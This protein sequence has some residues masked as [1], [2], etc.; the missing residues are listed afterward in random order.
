VRRWISWVLKLA[1]ALVLSLYAFWTLSLVALRYVDPPTTGVQIQRRVEAMLSGHKYRKRYTFVP[2]DRI[3]PN[4]QHAVL[5]SEDGHF[6]RHHGIDWEQ[7]ELVARQ[8]RETG[9]ISRGASTITQQLVKNLFFTTHRNPVRKAFEYTLAPLADSILG[10]KRELELYLNIV[11]WG[12]GVWGA[13]AASQYHYHMSAAKLDR[14]EAARLAACLPSPRR[15]RPAR[16]N[17]M[18]ASIMDRMR[19]MNW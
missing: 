14:E 15:R 13:E 19:M 2:L 18:S 8:S 7:T 12:P 17:D 3:S 5:A 1:I 4:L 6:Y 10:K 11:E 9:K 16:M